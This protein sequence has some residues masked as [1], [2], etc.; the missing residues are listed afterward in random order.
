M[1]CS[2]FDMVL[3]KNSLYTWVPVYNTVNPC[4][5][6]CR[7]IEGEFSEKMLDA[8]IDGTL[9]YEIANKRDICIN[10]I[11]KTIG[12]DY[13]IE[14]KAAEDQCGVCLGDGSAC[15]TVTK[16]FE[17]SEGLGY[18]DVGLIPEG[19][20]DIRV[21]EIAEAGNFLAL[22]SEDP[23]KY[24]LN[25]GFVIQWNGDYKV[26]G[27]TFKYERNGNLENLTAPGPT[28]EPVWIQL[29][30]QET[31]PGIRYEYTIKKDTDEENTI[32]QLVFSWEYGLWTR[33]SAL[34]GTGVRRQIVRCVEK[35]SGVVED[36]FCNPRSRPDNK[37]Q[38]CNEPDCP[39]RWWAGEWQK[40]SK[41]C[42]FSGVKK[43]T[44]L[45]IQTVGLDE[46]ALPVSE[47]KHLPRPRA[48]LPC[49]R[50]ILCSSNWTVGIWGEC[51]ASCGGGFRTRTVNCTRPVKG[52]CVLSKKPNARGLCALR[53]CPTKKKVLL[54]PQ[55]PKWGKPPDKNAPDKHA[56]NKKVPRAGLNHSGSKDEAKLNRMSS[57]VTTTST[58][59]PGNT[60]VQPDSRTDTNKGLSHQPTDRDERQKSDRSSSDKDFNSIA[61]HHV[62]VQDNNSTGGWRAPEPVSIE[63]TAIESEGMTGQPIEV[64]AQWDGGQFLVTEVGVT[65]NGRDYGIEEP[66]TKPGDSENPT[67]TEKPTLASTVTPGSLT[68]F[69]IC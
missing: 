4:E 59:Q 22:R 49:N 58:Q 57:T 62:T 67:V 61:F 24:F 60:T 55:R 52:S 25:G 19:A 56:P 23:E 39:A 51:S 8:V 16:T 42:G 69:K 28:K 38:K 11:C 48:Q 34:C 41:A 35:T 54:P 36:R 6:H 21:E 27:T 30:F 45:C 29:L 9:C 46:Q 33:C 7:P 3:Y 65:D 37:Q 2:E 32:R 17:E 1:Q 31:N 44:V 47:C 40:C 10:G 26:A 5:L 53:T 18:V 12:C 13:E 68:N 64:T 14:S 66:S 43:R 20:R 15:Q 63:P 50:D